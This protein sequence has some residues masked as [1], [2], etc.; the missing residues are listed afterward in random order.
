M[1]FE[2]VQEDPNPPFV[3]AVYEDGHMHTWEETV[4]DNFRYV[5]EREGLSD[6]EL[7][8]VLDIALW[9]LAWLLNYHQIPKEWKAIALFAHYA[10]VDLNYLL[11]IRTKG[12]KYCAGEWYDVFLTRRSTEMEK[13]WTLPRRQREDA[14]KRLQTVEGCETPES[15]SKKTGVSLR[16]C[17]AAFNT[18]F[19]SIVLVGLKV[20]GLSLRWLLTGRGNKSSSSA[21][22]DTVGSL[23]DAFPDEHSGYTNIH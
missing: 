16:T 23:Y 20:E 14:V 19:Q 2:L 13:D 8:N 5:Q 10:D 22:R 21:D 6:K 9:K 15:A 1:L 18:D 11:D 7:A 17:K 4:S 3:H 12:Q